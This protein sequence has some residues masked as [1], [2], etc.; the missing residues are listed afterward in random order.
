M[1][2]AA[3]PTT[4]LLIDGHSLAFRA[5]F[6]FAKGRDG[7]LRTATGIPTNICFGFLNSLLQVMQAQQPQLLAIAFDRREPTFR[8]EADASYKA[9]RPETPADFPPDLENLQRLLAAMRLPVITA[10]GFEADDV[11]GTLAL[12]GRDAGYQV[13]ILTGDRDLFQLIDA[14]KHITVL[15][16]DRSALRNTNGGI[17]EYDPATVEAKLGIK[18]TQVV[19]FKALCGDKSDN[20]PG[21]RG[22][23]EKTAV[24]L[25]T[26]YGSLA[27]VY[28]NLDAIKGATHKKL[29][30]GQADAERSQFLAQIRTDV[31][32]EITWAACQLT[33]FA[34]DEVQPIL[35]ELELK[36]FSRQI[37]SLQQQFS[38]IFASESSLKS[39]D[40]AKQ[41]TPVADS[42]NDDLWFFSAEDTQ[43][44][45]QAAVATI[46]I[47]PEVIDT[48][49]KLEQLVARL[50]ELGDRQQLVA[51][52]TE[53]TALNPR[54]AALVGL[55]C[56]W[57]AEPQQVAYLPVGHETGEQLPLAT[58]SAALQPILANSAYPKAFQN[59]KFDRLVLE[60]QG[61]L[62]TGVTFDT[63][64][65][66][67]VINPDRSHNLSDLSQRYLAG[68]E[69]QNYK[70]LGI[71]KGETIATLPISQVAVYCGMDA[72]ATF[73]LVPELEAELAQEP[74]LA[75]LLYEIEQPLEPVLAA[76]EQCGISI[77]T[78]YLATLSVQ[79][80][81]TL[82]SLEQQ[83]HTSVGQ[84]FNLDSPKQL[85][86]LLF[87]TL[88]LST[89]KSR[90][91]KT[92]YSTDHATLEKLQGDHPVIDR[93][94]E[95]RS[96]AKLKST[97]V[98]ALPALVEP[99][100]GRVHTDFNQ[101]VTATGRLSSSNPNLQNIPIRSEFSRQ[102]RQ[103]FLPQKGWL[104]VSADYSQVEL[105]ILAHLSGEPILIA[106]Y[107]ESQDVHAVTA[108]LLFEKDEVT[109]DE[110]R[111]GKTI[112]FGVIYGMGPQRF[113]REAGVSSK[114]GKEFIERYRDRYAQVFAFLETAKRQAIAQ[115]YVE[116]IC[117]RRRYFNFTSER[118]RQLR[119]Q[120][121]ETIKLDELKGLTAGDSQ[122]LRAAANAPIQGSSADIIKIAM[123]RLHEILR[124]YEARLLLQ[125]HDELVFE[126]PPAEWSSLEPQIRATME[127]AVDLQVPLV[128]DVRA[129]QNWMAAK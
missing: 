24:Q 38:G 30:V 75:K 127:Q 81:E 16:P 77:D 66:S 8:H 22:I 46:T 97:Y 123:V 129:G 95:Y 100:T 2:A 67:Y 31:P 44:A 90:K 78:H 52:D 35:A 58:V 41:I 121:P 88:G 117:Q 12:R 120:A 49:T 122:L 124:G 59:A 69:S 61:I 20:I 84:E 7:G 27:D 128:V 19:D 87:E 56:C 14:E 98:D 91:I 104:L 21:V 63:M 107:R 110:R 94:L 126:V 1:N 62:V 83:A 118:L 50:R 113:A 25:L 80:E 79:L 39:T 106:A 64:L 112:N 34:I 103:A 32:L 89:K 45:Q 57:G 54:Q 119:G 70:D 48:E 102:I 105:R 26:Q 15:Y 111:L 108:R 5:Y 47:Q 40:A 29:V 60:N 76:M 4:L 68:I 71:P 23:G 10:A 74:A 42:Q 125:V 72:Y 101:A 96:L 55:A 99:Q 85:S 28:A 109:P 115:G 36:K 114:Q 92:G 6:A 11:L 43:Q 9:D 82:R 53:T 3:P 33:G 13:K 93:V 51:W 17:M 116:T 73:C 65:A 37:E 86:T 18:P